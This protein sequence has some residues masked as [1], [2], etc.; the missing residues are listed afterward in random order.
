M[1]AD[2]IA[3]G[4]RA[5]LLH[6]ELAYSDCAHAMRE[7]WRMQKKFTGSRRQLERHVVRALVEAVERQA[8]EAAATEA[9][10]TMEASRDEVKASDH[11]DADEPD[12]P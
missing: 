6:G 3:L 7:F 4:E 5:M 2:A 10:E 12:M 9:M 1:R 8:A 11:R